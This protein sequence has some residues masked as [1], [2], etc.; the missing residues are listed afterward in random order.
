MASV[1]LVP[2][3]CHHCGIWLAPPPLELSAACVSCQ[4]AAEVVPGECYRP[5]DIPLFEKIQRAV[6][7]AQLSEPSTYRIWVLLSNASERWHRPQD[8]L[9]PVVAAIPALRA[10]QEDLGAERAQLAHMVGMSL[11]VITAQLRAFD[12]RRRSSGV[13][14]AVL[15]RPLD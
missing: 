3:A 13:L 15:E 5:D 12:A 8:L 14:R 4:G 6:R 10:I 9:G 11:A 1:L 2:I 7:G